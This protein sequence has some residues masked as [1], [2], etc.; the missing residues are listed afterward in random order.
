MPTSNSPLRSDDADDAGTRSEEVRMRL[1]L[2]KLGTRSTPPVRNRPGSTKP[3]G[4]AG[5]AH[6]APQRRHKFAREGE[7][8]VEHMPPPVRSPGDLQ[9]ELTE[10]RA[11]RQRAEQALAEAQAGIST[12]QAALSQSERTARAAREVVEE[13]EA[14]MAGLRAELQRTAVELETALANK[15]AVPL[16]AKGKR[17]TTAQARAKQVQAASGVADPQPVKWWLPLTQPRG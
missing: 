4:A 17:G 5:S 7:V 1:A 15:P 13:R 9:R 10:E 11:S 8:P 16:K 6:T 2:E 12:R 3:G 14:A